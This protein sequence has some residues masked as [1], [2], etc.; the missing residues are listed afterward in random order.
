[1]KKNI[2]FYILS[3]LYNNESNIIKDKNIN[4][5]LKL[6]DNT[7]PNLKIILPKG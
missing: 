6:I 4:D 3:E 1:M 2:I 5:I 7:K